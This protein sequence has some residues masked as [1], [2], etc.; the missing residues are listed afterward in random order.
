MTFKTTT[1]QRHSYQRSEVALGSIT[2]NEKAQRQLREHRVAELT[3]NLDLDMIGEPVLNFV[4]EDR[5]HVID[6]QHRIEA[7]KRFLGDGWEKAKIPC[8]VY[9][10]LSEQEE[11]DMF[12]RLDNVLSVSAFDKFQVRVTAKREIESA[13]AK[14]VKAQGL[15]IARSNGDGAIGAVTT[16]VRI[17]KRSSGEV[18]G[19]SLHI[20][21]EAFGDAGLD[22][23]IIDGVSLVCHR[24]NGTLDDDAAIARLRTTRAGAAGLMGRAVVVHKQT[25]SA[26]SQCIASAVVEAVNRGRGGKKL[27]DWWTA[28]A[29]AN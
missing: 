7:L 11:A 16:L 25:G 23:K 6:G 14:I 20:I 27:P 10:G 15:T 19:R 13:V 2:V 1:K 8:R 17:Y 9:K 4:A 28:S 21:R 18:L 5:Y 12:D 24:Y 3:A 22:A 29:A 26:L